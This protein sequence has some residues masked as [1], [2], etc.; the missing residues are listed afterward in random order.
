MPA[1][2]PHSSK[3]KTHTDIFPQGSLIT[4]TPHPVDPLQSGLTTV[5]S[6]ARCGL[7]A[8]CLYCPA[9][10]TCW[11]CYQHS[12]HIEWH[13][14][15]RQGRC[16]SGEWTEPVL[17]FHS[18]CDSQR[19]MLFLTRCQRGCFCAAAVKKFLSCFILLNKNEEVCSSCSVV[20]CRK[21]NSATI[22]YPVYHT[23]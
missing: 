3:K 12:K 14:C 23:V 22:A 2:P 6:S 9:A 5:I 8:F 15:C 7:S 11:L 1:P 19:H 18:S 20:H 10:S 21:N 13:G 4:V 17:V 16:L